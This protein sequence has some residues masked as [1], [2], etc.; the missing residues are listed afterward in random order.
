[1]NHETETIVY[2]SGLIFGLGLVIASGILAETSGVLFFPGVI[3][4]VVSVIFL[5]D[6]QS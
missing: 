4:A 6:R 5:A 1:M 3:V 2:A